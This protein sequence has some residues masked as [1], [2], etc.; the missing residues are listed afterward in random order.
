MTALYCLVGN[1]TGF[2]GLLAPF[3]NETV[4]KASIVMLL[5]HCFHFEFQSN[6]LLSIFGDFICDEFLELLTSNVQYEIVFLA[7]LLM[8][9]LSRFKSFLE[10]AGHS[11]YILEME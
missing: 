3:E 7:L 8:N 1:S 4:M 9:S 6:T 10:Q 2:H 5:K 11:K